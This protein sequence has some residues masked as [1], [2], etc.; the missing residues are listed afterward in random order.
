MSPRVTLPSDIAHAPIEVT[1]ARVGR[2]WA[3]PEAWPLGARQ[4]PAARLTVRGGRQA[5]AQRRRAQRG[6]LDGE[7]AGGIRPT[8]ERAQRAEERASGAST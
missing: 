8:R 2:G 7:T 3:G 4:H 5:L 1:T 6:A